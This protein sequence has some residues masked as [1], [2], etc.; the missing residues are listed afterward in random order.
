MRSVFLLGFFLLCG[1]V[2]S[3][4]SEPFSKEIAEYL[5]EGKTPRFSDVKKAYRPS[6]GILL[7]S[8][9]EVLQTLRLEKKY[10]R[11]EWTPSSEVPETLVLSLLAQEDRRFPFHSG[12]DYYAIL[13]SLK[14]RIVGNSKRG[15]STISM[16]LAG[17][18][19][20]TK[21]GTRTYS[22][23]W[24]QM[25]AAKRLEEIWTK[26]EIME[27][28]WNLVPFKGEYLGLRAASR[29]IFGVDPSSLAPEEAVLLVALLPNPN[30]SKAKWI[31][32]ASH[33]AKTIGREDL[34]QE[35]E[36]TISE[37]K[38]PS[39]VWNTD[40]YT[41]Y[42]AAYRI[43]KKGEGS[44][45]SLETG[46]VQTTIDP[47]LQRK[48]EAAMDRVLSSIQERNVKEAGILVLDNQ[49]GAVLVYLGNSK[50][51]KEN[52]FVDSIHSR[53]QAGSTLKPFLYSIAFERNLLEPESVLMDEP[54]DWELV[55]GSYKPGN[56]EERYMGPV[57][58]RVAL[59]SS[60]NVPAVQVLDW[61]G[62][63]AFVSKLKELGFQKLQSPEFYGLSLALGTA[64]VTL[65]ELTNAYRTIANNGSYTEATFDSD[66]A[67]SNRLQSDAKEL[68]G[69]K[70]ILSQEAS[71]TV[72]EILSSRDNRA[73]SFGW[74]SNLSTRFYTFA[75]TGTSQ[76]MRDN[77]CI[78]SSGNYTVGVWVGN[79]S[80]EP[81]YDVSGVTGAAPLWKEIMQLLQDYR[82][83][84]PLLT[85]EEKE[86]KE[87][88][89]LPT[90][91]VQKGEPRIIYPE[92][93]NLFAIDPEIPE[94]NE[95]IRFMVRGSA[96]DL[97]WILNGKV[98]GSSK[99]AYFDWRP[100]RGNHLLSVREKNGK[101]SETVA[102][103]VR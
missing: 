47:Y 4:F 55:G 76:D 48:S 81:M 92:N 10:R 97:E 85:Q 16:Q 6:E 93:G 22:D 38:R 83:S 95:R 88:S 31:S 8:K 58:A 103:Q 26:S 14:D 63:P 44:S 17:F 57:P 34:T 2:S 13:G 64:D 89:L 67:S 91:N 54:K 59:A 32:R 77:W 39:S 21:P 84:N 74:E 66:E 61:V 90:K 94:E 11:L 69:R 1:F 80:G 41:A 33:L 75:K 86:K 18:L 45:D 5:Q 96:K 60:L 56:Y 79:M 102:F 20:G 35:I 53:R 87:L 62:V 19:L 78:G 12:V 72:R 23:K 46:R 98:I 42:H 36:I 24:S 37:Y 51:S 52:Y 43:F 70:Q 65:W 7:D 73:P 9:G 40:N 82:P 50:L 49:S 30:V 29:G 71:K 99:L 15:A 27:A 3:V 101:L 68:P 28:Y 25:K 100:K